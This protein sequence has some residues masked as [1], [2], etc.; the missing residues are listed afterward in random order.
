MQPQYITKQ[1]LIDTNVDLTNKDVDTLL[2][3]LNSLLEERIGNEITLSLNDT[4]I[5]EL[6]ALQDSSDDDVVADWIEAHVEDLDE[7]IENE[8]DILIGEFVELDGVID[9]LLT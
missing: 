9:N 7:L 8:Q 4:Q 2:D 1:N 5:E 6:V 3:Q